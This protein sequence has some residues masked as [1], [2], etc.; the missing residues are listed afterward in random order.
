M[1][2]VEVQTLSI[3]VINI[4]VKFSNINRKRFLYYTFLM[5][6]YKLTLVITYCKNEFLNILKMS[7]F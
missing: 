3:F 5:L 2:A 1:V 7:K 4:L 6:N